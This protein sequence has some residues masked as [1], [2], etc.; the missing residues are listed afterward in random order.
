MPRRPRF[1]RS[2]PVTIPE[3]MAAPDTSVD[4][5]DLVSR[6]DA[7][8]K[9]GT[10]VREKALAALKETRVEAL[11]SVRLSFEAGR[12][13]G[14][15]AARAIAAIHDDL[16]TALFDFT[17]THIIHVANPTSGEHMAVCAVG[18]YG[19]GEMAPG[20]DVD[21]LFLLA[22][23]KGSPYTEQVTEYMLYMLWDMGLKVGHATRSTEQCIK[24]A[25][26]D[27]TILTT[28]LDLRY[29][30]GEED[31][32]LALF[33]R[34]RKDITKG[35][36]R[37]F[38]ATKL[39]ERDARHAR[40][41]NSRY[42]IEPNVKEG[43]GGLRDLHVLYWIARFLDRDG[44]IRDAQRAEDYVEL[45]LFDEAAA[46]R[47]VRAADFLWRTRLY[48]HFTAGRATETLSFDH[49]TVLSRKMGYAA[50]PIE[51]A[52]EKFMREYFTNAREVGALTRIA[53]AKLEAEKSLRLP[54]GLD[55]LLPNSRRKLKEEDFILDHGRLMFRD[56]MTLREKPALIMELFEIAGR[57]NLDIHPDALSAVD[58]RRN[59]IDNNFRRDPHVSKLFQRIL[60]GS[61][62]PYAT[63]K[64]MNEAGVLGRY[65]LE[66]GGIVARTQ[67][68]MHHA[69][70]VDEH[71]L[72]LVNYLHDLESGNLADENPMV[73][74]IVKEFDE[75][76]RRILYMT[77][78]L[79]DTG[80]GVGDQCIEGARLS[81]RACRRIG[82]ENSEIDSISWLVRRHLDMSDTAQRRDISDP[83]TIA[84][85]A[86]L[87]GSLPRLKMLAVLTV[88]DI[89]AVGP[90][91]WNDWKGVLLRNLYK[92][93]AAYLEGRDDLEPAAK[94]AAAREQLWERLP[95]NMAAR[96]TP[97]ADDLEQAYW[98]GF[99]MESLVRHAR[100]FDNA[101][102]AGDDTAVRTRL[103]KPRDITEL[104]ILTRDRPGL[105]ADLTLAISAAGAQIIGAKLHTGQNGR[106][107]NVFYLQN[108]EGLAYGRVNSKLLVDLR[109][110]TKAVALGQVADI[111]ISSP[112]LSRRAAAIPVKPSVKILDTASGN[113]SIIEIEGR[114]RPGLLNAL[115]NCL[116][117]AGLDVLS[118]HVEVVGTRAIDAFYVI[119]LA[120]HKMTDTERHQISDDLLDILTEETPI[121]VRTNMSAA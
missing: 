105:F 72:R 108:V 30:C 120:N 47:F 5:Q 101:L 7:I 35:K 118:A 94:A 12:Y 80:K 74:D 57:R 29:L 54:K 109:K 68:N 116:R 19:R 59:L 79:H 70:T 52:V 99:N 27:Q 39:E 53:C 96:V 107:M 10:K 4:T 21:L 2:E 67:F 14:L 18:G 83:E 71:T 41:G 49:Q 98:L 88:V 69:Y 112:T 48:L 82:L 3:R 76:R 86:R 36:G 87:V 95:G 78:L 97:I 17:T 81:R 121:E 104:W 92:A 91:I 16:I 85:F 25:K 62:A 113:I 89:R 42:V 40:E 100:F 15:E 37:D 44:R 33:T 51:E 103:D 22:D 106:V 6:L 28:L 93:T 63:L 56:P 117:D 13:G 84:E 50:G 75:R 24:L 34:F 61:K 8:A 45:G 90:G 65:L 38:I 77:C 9:D 43:K 46:Q 26:T 111:S 55:A 58:F 66:F 110:D 64:I 114:D 20:S 31:M 11:N 73:T 23:N 60:L 119:P 1:I 102:E 32:A 115:A